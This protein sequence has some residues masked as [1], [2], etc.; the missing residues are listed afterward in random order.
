MFPQQDTK[1][2]TTTES[3]SGKISFQFDFSTGDFL[4]EDGK[5][6]SLSGFEA[7]KMWIT[8]VLKT[9]KYRFKIYNSDNVE[10]YGASLQE[11]VTS[12]YPMEFIKSE[13]Q[14]EVTETLLKNTGIKSIGNFNFTRD[15]RTLNV[16]FD[17]STVYGTIENEVII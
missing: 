1:L 17:V 12:G 9:E 8:K 13:V 14:R 4:I 16:K 5:V 11:I 10:K 15:K 6:K 2:N 7:L 3:P